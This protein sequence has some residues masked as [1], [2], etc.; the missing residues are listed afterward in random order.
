M[1]RHRLSAVCIV[2]ATALAAILVA[3][4]IQPGLIGLAP[5]PG[6]RQLC[7][8]GAV[9]LIVGCAVATAGWLRVLV[10]GRMSLN[11]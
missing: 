6:I 1:W 5:S 4:V 9:A 8:W 11:A 2:E 7:G 10:T 3:V